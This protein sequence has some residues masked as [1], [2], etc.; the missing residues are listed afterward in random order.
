MKMD[1]PQT[2]LPESEREAQETPRRL[3]NPDFELRDCSNAW[4]VT[5]I[6]HDQPETPQSI[7]RSFYAEPAPRT[8]QA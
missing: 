3:L 8:R 6:W 7:T 2:G 4:D 5:E 1:T